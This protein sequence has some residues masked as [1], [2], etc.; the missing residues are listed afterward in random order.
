MTSDDL[1]A[2]VPVLLITGY[3]AAG[4]TFLVNRLLDHCHERGQ[5]CG[6]IAHRAAEEFGITP[7]PIEAGRAAYSDEV[8]DF[9]SGCLCCSPRG[10]MSRLLFD[11]AWRKDDLDVLII[12]T[13]PLAS[14][15]V[16]AKSVLVSSDAV[17][18]RFELRSII[19]VVDPVLA[20]RHLAS[21]SPEW[22]ARAQVQAS[23]LVL[24]NLRAAGD[25]GEASM[26]ASDDALAAAAALV[27]A[28]QPG[29]AVETL[30]QNTGALDAVLSAVLSRHGFRI[31]QARALDPN[32]DRVTDD[33]PS[34]LSLSGSHDRRLGAHC[35]VEASELFEGQLRPLCSRLAASGSVLRI[36]GVIR[37]RP[38]P[39]PPQPA[40]AAASV[41]EAAAVAPA[42][43]AVSVPSA[44]L[45]A[46]P[47]LPVLPPP[48]WLLVEGVEGQL[49]FRT[50]DEPAPRATSCDLD[51]LV[52]TEDEKMPPVPTSAPLE[53]MPLVPASAAAAAAGGAGGSVAV[54]SWGADEGARRAETEP[55][56]KIFV[57][58]RGLRVGSLR[59]EFQQCAVPESY[60]Y[61]ADVEL[62]FG[63][64]GPKPLNAASTEKADI[65]RAPSRARVVASDLPGVWV[66][67][68]SDETDQKRQV[69]GRGKWTDGSPQVD[70]KRQV[71][72]PK[73]ARFVAWRLPAAGN[74][75][76]RAVSSAVLNVCEDAEHGECV[77]CSS[78]QSP[79]TQSPETQSPETQS[80]GGDHTA[81]GTTRSTR[82]T[83]IRY[84]LRDGVALPPH[85][86][87][88]PLTL[89]QV[90][91]VSGGVFVSS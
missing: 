85:E 66:A 56:S 49:T 8:F 61:A 48:G 16:F 11:L 72:G 4:K 6:V 35:A 32:F 79:E 50:V 15:L 54:F 83:T 87:S 31:E 19:A 63:S 42:E 28:I 38:P 59:R 80:A 40:S 7:Y 45:P 77:A 73:K 88:P 82:S 44:A 34:I 39:R 70:P 55:L 17:I 29:V 89:L 25:G 75:T 10:E 57:L 43:T 33:V 81:G 20:P 22:Q 64:R 86:G 58:G 68:L 3:A 27:S 69:D 91:V 47:A 74:E 51:V 24:L 36:K 62:H 9:G 1:R 52:T 23:D 30:P 65:P 46:L 26:N 21:E 76:V 41:A 2:R 60:R 78:S 84:R 12:R 13:G 18:A 37:L 5:K 67:R 71:D 14:P 90:E 53:K